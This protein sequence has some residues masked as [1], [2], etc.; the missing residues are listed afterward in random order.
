MKDLLLTQIKKKGKRREQT[1]YTPGASPSEPTLPRN[2]RP[3]DSPISPTPGP[4][5]TS[6]PKTEQISQSIAKK[7][8]AKYYKLVFDGNELQKLIKRVEAEAEIEVD[9]EEDI[10][11]Q[12]IFIS[13]SEEVKE[14]IEAMQGYEEKNW[15]KLKEELTTEWGR[16]DPDRRYILE[17]LEKLFTN[18]KR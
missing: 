11:R 8:R 16:V 1:S 18:T 14:K 2:V 3:E 10:E 17:S 7:I 9:S 13:A 12:F 6:T 4:R 5:A 15:T